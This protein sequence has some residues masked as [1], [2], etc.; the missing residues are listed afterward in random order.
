MRDIPVNG[1]A[2]IEAPPAPAHALATHQSRPHHP[3]QPRRKRVRLR[4]IGSV[5]NVAQVGACKVLEPG[6]ALAP[7]LSVARIISNVV[8]P[9]GM[10]RK[11][12]CSCRRSDILEMSTR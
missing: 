10:I 1:A 5:H 3:R 4:D 6:S 9:L 7:A 12:R 11:A 8:A 2:Q